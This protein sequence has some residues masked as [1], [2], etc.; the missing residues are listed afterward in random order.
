MNYIIESNIDFY[1]ELQRQIKETRE[2][3]KKEENVKIP[4]PSEHA[5][6]NQ[7][8]TNPVPVCLL[9]NEPLTINCITLDCK[10]IFNYLPLY[11]EVC[12]QKQDNC[13]ETTYLSINEIKCPYCRVV[14]PK[15]LPYIADPGVVQKKKGVNFPLKYCMKL[16]TCGWIGNKGKGKQ[17]SADAYTTVQGT[18]CIQHQN[19]VKKQQQDKQD[20]EDIVWTAQHEALNKKYKLVELKQM[21]REKKLKVGGTKKELIMLF[22]KNTLSYEVV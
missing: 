22:E 19:K 9:T 6:P 11:K 13:L 10:H 5:N 2:R 17:C 18:Y 1:A 7:N 12:Y 21:L 8:E 20:K 15:L 3:E 16:H 14:T 4:N